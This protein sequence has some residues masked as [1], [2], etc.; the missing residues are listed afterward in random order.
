MTHI[1]VEEYSD[2]I[3]VKDAATGEILHEGH[4]LAAFH[5][6]NI[7]SNYSVKIDIEYIEE[8]GYEYK[9]QLDPRVYEAL[10]NYKVESND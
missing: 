7:L 4:S 6:A 2:W 9:T 3:K 10:M 8:E 1:K 5:W